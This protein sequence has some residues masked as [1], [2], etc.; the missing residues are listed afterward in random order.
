MSTIRLL[1]QKREASQRFRERHPERVKESDRRY[2]LQPNGIYKQLK[3]INCNPK[4]R[5]GRTPQLLITK[6]DFINWYNSQE[7]VCF[8]CGRTHEEATR[9]YK[10]K[11]IR[12]LTIDRI[13]N[14]KDYSLE[15]IVLACYFCNKIKGAFFSKEE[16]IKIGNILK[17]RI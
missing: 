16:M 12:R 6:L 8:Y 14:K 11:N 13:D 17:D 4:Q 7:K 15:N 5:Y 2:S 1:K 9:I 10:I 3:G